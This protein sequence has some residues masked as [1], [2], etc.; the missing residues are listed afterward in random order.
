MC[1]DLSNS[2]RLWEMRG[3]GVKRGTESNV[4]T[5]PGPC[6]MSTAVSNLVSIIE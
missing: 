2:G 3:D 5:E 1:D 4:I 6:W